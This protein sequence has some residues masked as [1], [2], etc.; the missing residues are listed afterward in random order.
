MTTI[1]GNNNN[2]IITTRLEKITNISKNQNVIICFFFNIIL[3]SVNIARLWEMNLH[4]N[5]ETYVL[6]TA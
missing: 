6:F 4:K 3:H 1:N 5:N 2:K